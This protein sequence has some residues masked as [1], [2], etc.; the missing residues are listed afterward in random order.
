M[1]Q[2]HSILPKPVLKPSYQ[3]SWLQSAQNA[4][5]QYPQAMPQLAFQ[6]SEVCPVDNEHVA[7]HE[8]GEGEHA[9]HVLPEEDARHLLLPVLVDGDNS[10]QQHKQTLSQCP[11]AGFPAMTEHKAASGTLCG[12]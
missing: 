4:A 10:L 3:C 8:T 9:A 6:A 2:Q 7:G 5:R 1:L 12:N 11:H